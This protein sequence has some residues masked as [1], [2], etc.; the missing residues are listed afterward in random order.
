MARSIEEIKNEIL[1]DKISRPE[2]DGLNSTSQT[3]EWL[4]WVDV[5]ANAIYTEESFIDQLKAE[6]DQK[7]DEQ[8]SGTASWYQ[9]KC[10]EFQLGDDLQ[11]DGT[12]AV[13]DET[14]QIITRASV[15]ENDTGVLLI[16]VAKGSVG[17]ETQ[18]DSSELSQFAEYIEKIKFAG[19]Q[20]S[21]ISLNAD[22]MRI[23]GT[24]YYDPI[25]SVT[26]IQERV[27]TSLETYIESEIPFNGIILY[28]TIVDVL[29]RVDGVYDINLSELMIRASGADNIVTISYQLASGYV[30]ESTTAGESF[31]DT[32]IYTPMDQLPEVFSLGTGDLPNIV[33]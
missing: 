21:V 9:T 27:R 32:L 19:T 33:H 6:I 31:E 26:Q 2:L 15:T 10:F 11:N 23:T 1:Q 5:I 18:L 12:Y 13:I 28:N 7:I 29:Q 22:E 8:Q 16:K 25:F 30:K 4:L 20:V 17:N 14:K 24:I 3:A